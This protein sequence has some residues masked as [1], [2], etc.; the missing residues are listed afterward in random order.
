M[1]RLWNDLLNEPVVLFTVLSAVMVAVNAE[2]SAGW[3]NIATV[4]VVAVGAALTRHYVKPT[5]KL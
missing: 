4:A 5:R 2:V 3:F 1:L